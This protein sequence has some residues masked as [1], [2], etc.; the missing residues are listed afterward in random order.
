[1]SLRQSES[2]LPSEAFNQ[3][4]LTSSPTVREWDPFRRPCHWPW[5]KLELGWTYSPLG[6]KS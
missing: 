1:M 2:L 4:L 3:R 5:L 6:A